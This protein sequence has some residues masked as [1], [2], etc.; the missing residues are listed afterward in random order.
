M[1]PDKP[2][3][4]Y[5]V[6]TERL[7]RLWKKPQSSLKQPADQHPSLFA[8]AEKAHIL[9]DRREGIDLDEA[10]ELCRLRVGFCLS[11]G[12]VR[13]RDQSAMHTMEDMAK[14]YDELNQ[15][16]GCSL[17]L[18]QAEKVGREIGADRLAMTHVIDKLTEAQER[19]K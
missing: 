14:I 8:L 18:M 2:S 11:S 7:V 5:S 6:A 1:E 4:P 16:R 13:Y 10:L 17:W 19:Q 15:L 3:S 12:R 9:M